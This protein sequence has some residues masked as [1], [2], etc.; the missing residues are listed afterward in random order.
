[1]IT[2]FLST[3]QT[4]VISA[5][6]AL[7]LIVGGAVGVRTLS[8]AGT[9]N[10]SSTATSTVHVASVQQLMNQSRTLPAV[11][12]VV[13]DKEIAIRAETQGT[14]R[15][16]RTKEGEFVQNGE[17]L[18]R[19]QADT[20][21]ANLQQAQSNTQAQ[22]A[23]LRQLRQ[24]TGSGEDGSDLSS[25]IDQ[26]RQLTSNAY[27]RLLN[28][29]LRA[30]PADPTDRSG[31]APTISGYYTGNKEGEYVIDV[32]AS[33]GR[34]GASFKVSGLENNI[35]QEVTTDTPVPLG[36]NGLYIQ[37]P[38]DFRTNETWVV[39]I[40]NTRSSQYVNALNAYQS[41]KESSE[42]S[43]NQART[44]TEEIRAQRERV[45]SAEANIAAAKSAKEKT[46]ITAPTDGVVSDISVD[47]GEVVNVST[48]IGT[49]IGSTGREIHLTLTNQ[50]ASRISA[51]A[52]A[53]VDGRKV[54][55]VAYIAEAI[56]A[57]TQKKE[58]HIKIDQ[59]STFTV[60]EYVDIEIEAD[61]E[62]AAKDIQ[63]PLTALQITADGA[64]TLRVGDDNTLKA[65]PVTPGRLVGNTILIQDGLSRA[66]TIV[67]DAR[68][69]EAGDAVKV[70][71]Q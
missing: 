23:Q 27:R 36:K 65:V 10:E 8:S 28:T 67:V 13:A 20:Q 29:D 59:P 11:G 6:A 57:D 16:L 60:G 2:R 41:T 44:N 62:K 9:V 61:K 54:G 35:Y 19:I 33:D 21:Q 12:E 3:A 26:Q 24:N 51:G 7:L 68:G 70:S 37:F 14:V 30:Y 58:V 63:I 15:Q 52:A 31:S 40:P 55:E 18:A 46:V 5:T 38:E 66:D 17:V 48:Q 4:K 53:Y 25:T 42:R 64:Q 32:Y 50:Q 34:L 56:D 1:M 47:A 43:I 71:P 39:P 45:K 49:V 69:L 22:K